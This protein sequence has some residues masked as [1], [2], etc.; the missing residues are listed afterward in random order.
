MPLRW[1]DEATFVSNTMTPPRILPALLL[2]AIAALPSE[3]PLFSFAVLA[4]VQYAD[5]DTAGAREYRASLDKLRRTVVE[6]NAARPAFVV[7]LGDLI[8]AGADNLE[9]I[10]P[11]WNSLDASRYHVLGNHDFALP[12]GEL[13]GRLG[14]DRA[15]YDFAHSGWRFV[16]LDG[17]DVSVP[18]TEPGGGA[19]RQAEEMLAQ[20]RRDK[21]PNA[22]AWNGAVSPEQMDWL[23][24]VLDDACGKRQRVMVF[25]H[26]PVL[27]AQSTPQHLLWNADRVVQVL[28]ESASV[29]AF[30]N[31]HDHRGGYA[32]RG[33][34]HFVTLPGLVESGATLSWTLI[35]VY[36]DRLEFRGR[37]GAPSRNLGLRR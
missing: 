19:R 2:T 6:V 28:S 24:G 7:Q 27:A 12:R 18:G 23:R 9:R 29:A 30:L 3:A 11:V 16:V 33:G 32:E 34:I 21:R 22:Q 36:G 37:G 26:F 5:K 17:M 1:Y 15:W 4:D 8:D 31:G 13:L 10:L 20:L 14:M 35:D 25:C